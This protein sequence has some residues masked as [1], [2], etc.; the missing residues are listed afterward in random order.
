MKIKF[1]NFLFNESVDLNNYFI[2]KYFLKSNDMLRAAKGI[3][4]GQSIGNPNVRLDGETAE[5]LENHLAVIL[6]HPENLKNKKEAIVKIAY[7]VKNLNLEEDGVTQLTCIVMGGQMDIEEILSCRLMDL[8]LPEIFLKTFKGPK[9]GMN[10]IKKRTNSIGRP[11]LGGIVKPKTGLDIETLK[12]V[13][14]NMVKGGVDFIKED[15]ILGNPSCCPFEERV[16]IVNDAVQNEAIK[17][18]KEVFYAPCVNSDLPYL[19][20]RIEFLVKQ[21][22]KAYHVNIWSGIN[23]YKYL[24]SFDFNI[25]MFYQKSGDRVLTDKNN[26]YSISWGVLLKL[27]RISGADFI[28]AGMWGGYLSDSKEDLSEWMSILTSTHKL[29]FNKTV[30]SFSCGSHPGLVDTTVKNFGKD[31]MMSLGGS[32]HGH[33]SGTISGAKA[34]RQAFELNKNS[35]ID[36]SELT[37]YNEAIEKWGYISD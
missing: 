36:K 22:L 29:G 27:A 37:E 9:I 33:P 1:D 18:N 17:L 16:K 28:H 13:C 26:P 34:M 7:P 12:T 32:L 24:R 6:D 14:V 3:A 10:N 35:E 11:L 4:I 5:L 19:L 31:V 15:E 20:K 8:E 23:M 25:A 30:P 2:A 21:N